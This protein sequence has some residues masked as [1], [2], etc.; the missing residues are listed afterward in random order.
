MLLIGNKPG[1]SA[2]T[3]LFLKHLSIARLHQIERVKSTMVKDNP[4]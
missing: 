4:N 2:K 3:S 1:R